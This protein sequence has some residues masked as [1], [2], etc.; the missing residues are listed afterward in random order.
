MTRFVNQRYG[1]KEHFAKLSNYETFIEK[2]DN[3]S[4]QNA[5]VRF[6]KILFDLN[7]KLYFYK[8]EPLVKH[9]KQMYENLEELYAKLPENYQIGLGSSFKEVM[10]E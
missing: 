2:T 10:K 8:E 7:N 9:F 1:L 3:T 4:G 5:I 6:Q